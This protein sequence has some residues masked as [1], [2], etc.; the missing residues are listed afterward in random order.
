[1][2]KVR[3]TKQFE[4]EMAHLLDNYDG[5]C[6]NIHGHSYKLS[7]TA[8]GEIEGNTESPKLG[9]VMDFSVLKKI[10]KE[11]IVDRLDHAMLVR[12]GTKQ[13]MQLEGI[14]ERIYT[15]PFQPTCENMVVDFAEKIR[16][17][18][19]KHIELVSVRLN[20]TAT[21]YAEWFAEDNE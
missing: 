4:F 12:E 15:V 17:N 16:A 14:A 18:L 2:A 11:N 8:R 1:M 20:E 10:V 19:P 6:Q 9:M 13:A 5:L 21:S 3:I 7:V